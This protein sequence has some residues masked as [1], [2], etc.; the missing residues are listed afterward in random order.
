MKSQSKNQTPVTIYALVD[1]ITKRT[2]YV[3]KTVN[4]KIRMSN[5][6]TPF[7]LKG[8]T[9]KANW[10]RS[11][12]NSGYLPEVKTLE[13]VPVGEDW[14]ER[15]KKWIAYYRSQ[16]ED[17]TNF[18]DGGEGGAT[19]YGRK[20]TAKSIEGLRNYS[21]SLAGKPGKPLTD[22]QKAT[23]SEKAKA[24]WAKWKQEGRKIVK[25]MSDSAKAAIGDKNRGRK[26]SAKTIENS[27]K[28]R[29]GK[30]LSDEHKAK[31]GAASKGRSNTEEQKRSISAKAKARWAGYSDERRKEI[32]KKNKSKIKKSS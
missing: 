6:L 15:E 18:T 27:I 24:R 16:G 25:S 20:P 14:A 13:I 21:K 22:E 1:P 9:H 10:L 28:S 5:H 3:G 19:G 2:R 23:I 29:K 8:K 7:R 30:H 31:I 26:P 12:V 17:L 11:L 32:G 4:L